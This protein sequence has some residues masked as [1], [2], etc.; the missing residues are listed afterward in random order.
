MVSW[1]SVAASLQLAKIFEVEFFP[2]WINVLF[3]VLL[4]FC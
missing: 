2:R 1:I 4:M 3:Q